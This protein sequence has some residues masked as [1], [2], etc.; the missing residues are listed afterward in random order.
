MV[1]GGG[2]REGRGQLAL[3]VQRRY[4]QHS[5]IVILHIGD[6]NHLSEIPTLR[7]LN[8]TISNPVQR[9]SRVI[10]A[11]QVRLQRFSSGKVHHYVD[12]HYV[13]I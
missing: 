1:A 10:I 12:V 2:G 8:F 13:R 11:E 6:T 4:E 9:L 5:E 3:E 7:P